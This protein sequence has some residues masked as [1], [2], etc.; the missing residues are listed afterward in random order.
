MLAL[1]IVSP[2]GRRIAS[3]NKT[4]EVRSWHPGELPLRNLLIVENSVYLSSEHPEDPNGR[5]VAL[6]DVIGVHNWH[7]SEVEAACSSGWQDGYLAWVLANVRPLVGSEVVP[8]RLRL[9]EV[10]FR[11]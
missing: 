6:V 8:A 2:G 1:S 10:E 7:E 4:I 11:L 9:Y 5:A 3:G